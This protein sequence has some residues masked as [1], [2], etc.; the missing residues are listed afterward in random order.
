MN[1]PKS[2][3]TLTLA[4]GFILGL[5]VLADA[6]ETYEVDPV[7]SMA[8][9]RVKHLGVSYTYGRFKDIS[10]TFVVD[11]QDPT[12]SSAEITI[13]TDSVTTDDE[14]RDQH[15]RSPDFFDAKQYPVM[16][17]KSKSVK[18]VKDNAYE[19]T[20]D[21]TLHGVTKSLSVTLEHVGVGKDPWGGQRSG[22]EGVFTLK[23]SDFGMSYMLEG[24]GDEVRV[25]L[26]VEG[27][28]K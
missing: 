3:K 26:G 25:I 22:F 10:G 5:S 1:I 14:K 13:K 16:S 2:F 17:F 11:E 20:G 4:L 18:K 24:I 28:R 8:V 15:L 6:G 27:I 21:F 9:F 12:K 19:V 7:H 23:R